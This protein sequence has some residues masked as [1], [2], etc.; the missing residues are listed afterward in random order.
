MTNAI[1]ISIIIMAIIL[2]LGLFADSLSQKL[3]LP[4]FGSI[5]TVCL[6]GAVLLVA[7]LLQK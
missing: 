7:V 4:N 3:K 6:V 2:A 1:I 5:L